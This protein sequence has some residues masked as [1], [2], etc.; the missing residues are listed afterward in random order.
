MINEIR[1]LNCSVIPKM[2][3]DKT[4]EK[5]IISREIKK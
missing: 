4:C 5:Q 3:V 2:E 1:E